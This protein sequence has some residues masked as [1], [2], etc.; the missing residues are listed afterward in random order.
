MKILF[1]NAYHDTPN[2]PFASYRAKRNKEGHI[3]PKNG[4]FN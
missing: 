1:F 2:H 4:F 3:S